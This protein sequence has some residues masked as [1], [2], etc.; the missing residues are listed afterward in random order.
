ML[1]GYNLRC[2]TYTLH[3]FRY[4]LHYIGYTLCLCGYFLSQITSNLWDNVWYCSEP[5]PKPQSWRDDICPR[6]KD[7]YISPEIG[8]WANIISVLIIQK[9]YA[10]ISIL[11]KQLCYFLSQDYFNIHLVS[12]SDFFYQKVSKI[13]SFLVTLDVL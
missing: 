2:L 4:I 12:L 13:L 10:Y 5:L 6:L 3:H 11:N 1:Q 9:L 8:F 7:P